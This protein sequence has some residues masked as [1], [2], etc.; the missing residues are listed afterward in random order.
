MP[1]NDS[2]PTPLIRQ[3]IARFPSCHGSVDR[4]EA[5]LAIVLVVV[6]P[7]EFPANFLI[8]AFDGMNASS[9]MPFAS[10]AGVAPSKLSHT[11]SGVRE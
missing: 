5:R 6:D 4:E 2:S 8:V 10:K 1:S 11:E 3:I 7:L 9:G